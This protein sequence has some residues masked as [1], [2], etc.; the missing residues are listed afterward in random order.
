MSQ[1]FPFLYS[2]QLQI[3]GQETKN[4]IHYKLYVAFQNGQNS[5]F[6]DPLSLDSRN[7]L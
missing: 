2:S 4:G 5:H 1:R 6:G 7:W 3:D